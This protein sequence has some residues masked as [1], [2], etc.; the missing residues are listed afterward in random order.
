MSMSTHTSAVSGN[1]ASFAE[2]SKGHGSFG[3]QYAA[4]LQELTFNSRP[5][6]EA[7]TLLAEENTAHALEI[8]VAIEERIEKAIPSQK[9]YSLYLLDSISKNIGLP[10]TNL[11][12]NNLFK[13]FT[14]TYGLVDDPTRCKL[15][16]LFK[17]WKVPTAATG[18]P[19]F[20]Q[21]QLDRI[22]EFLIK[23]T[24]PLV[25]NNRTVA[26]SM[27]NANLGSGGTFNGGPATDILNKDK[28]TL[29]N[30]TDELL[31]MVDARLK[32]M[33]DT[34]TQQ[35]YTLLNQL[36]TIL[37]GTSSIPQA[38]LD[39]VA[40]Q[41]HAIRTDEILKSNSIKREKEADRRAHV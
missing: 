5:I 13:T 24:N 37:G 2:P 9:L 17:T 35:R 18:L 4:S 21:G 15:I 12:S 1:G 11:F 20:D 31:R 16:K 29:I 38:Q 3:E 33:S 8:V 26:D 39:E 32:V 23:V 27:K 36:K 14:R 41:L 6:I 30:E 19:L 7:H 34:K 25:N 22:E 40:K 28:F 10:Y